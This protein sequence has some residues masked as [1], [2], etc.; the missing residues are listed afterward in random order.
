MDPRKEEHE[1]GNARKIYPATGLELCLQGKLSSHNAFR[2]PLNMPLAYFIPPLPCPDPPPPWL[3]TW[4]LWMDMAQA[5]WR[6]SC[7]RLRSRPP[8]VCTVQRSARMTSVTPHRNRTW[9]SPEGGMEKSHFSAL[10]QGSE[11]RSRPHLCI[12]HSSSSH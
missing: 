11:V 8:V 7:C 12:L 3:L 4:L 5:S 6:G 1:M 9:G 10:F 2:T